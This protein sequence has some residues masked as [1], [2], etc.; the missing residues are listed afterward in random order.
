MM[1]IPTETEKKSP[2]RPP[3]R[4]KRIPL[5]TRNV[6]TAPKR[7]GYVRRFVN[8]VPGRIQQFEAAGYSV[9]K[10]N[11]TVGDPKIGKDLDPGSPVSL[12]VGGGTKAVLMEIREDWYTEDQKAKQDK[13]LMAENDMKRNLNARREGSYGSVEIRR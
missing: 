9:V 1:S 10:E 11:I 5:G 2:G 3:K 13:I 4:P 12:S 8:D 6:L 7:P